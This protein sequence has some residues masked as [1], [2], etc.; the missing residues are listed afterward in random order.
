MTD[1]A[2]WSRVL[3][4][5][6]PATVHDCAATAAAPPAR[7]IPAAAAGTKATTSAA[8]ATAARTRLLR[9]TAVKPR[10]HLIA[11][12]A[13]PSPRQPDLLIVTSLPLAGKRPP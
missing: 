9:P 6:C 8:E 13:S 3:A 5:F 1:S 4:T 10:I 11:I 12:R 7:S 2:A